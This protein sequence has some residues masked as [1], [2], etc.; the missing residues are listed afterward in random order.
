MFVRLIVLTILFTGYAVAQEAATKP[1]ETSSLKVSKVKSVVNPCDLNRQR[2]K[3][4]GGTIA[5]GVLAF[6]AC[7]LG[8]DLADK[9]DKKKVSDKN[10]KAAVC[11]VAGGIVG[12]NLAADSARRQCELYEIAQKNQLQATFEE[13]VVGQETAA[14]VE[15]PPVEEKPK[16]E[17]KKKK[18]DKDD[19]DEDKDAPVVAIATF[20]GLEHFA[21][22]SANL[23]PQAKEYF[24]AIA[25]QYSAEGQLAS[26][27][28]ELKTEKKEDKLTPESEAEL[29]K[30]W[31][32]IKVVLVGHTDDTGTD[33]LN[34]SLS[35]ARA[36][37]VAEVFRNAG[38]GADKLYFQGAGSSLPIG[39]NRTDDGRARNRRVEVVE[40]PPGADVAGYLALRKPNPALFRPRPQPAVTA[41]VASAPA[42]KPT[43]APQPKPAKP[44][45]ADD[46]TEPAAPAP[47]PTVK[48][49][50]AP[51][52]VT[53]LPPL[54]IDFGGSL[55]PAGN[56]QVVAAMGPL[57]QSTGWGFVNA[58]S[59]P[60]DE[61]IYNV[62]CTRDDPQANV[63]LPAKQLAT[64][65]A[66]AIKTQEYLPGFN[67]SA[68]MGSVNGHRIGLN[69]V[70]ILREGNTA[71]R[72]PDVLVYKDFDRTGDQKVDLTAT[73]QVKLYEGEQGLLYRVFVQ[74]SRLRCI[75][76]VVPPKGSLAATAGNLYY[77]D[78]KKML[79]AP[80]LPS[81]VR[82]Q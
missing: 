57:K 79:A 10:K 51:V 47:K 80:Y 26:L 52:K 8:Q 75:D 82:A 44:A 40:L 63:G 61:T 72:N 55:A 81:R 23:T 6:A 28:A 66:Q 37:S 1:A 73:S 27:R 42:P 74:K 12:Y 41:I 60:G 43:P 67:D 5:A 17:K 13:V 32:E 62:P 59:A 15:A 76:V 68:W 16:K 20:G 22:G 14:A 4:V 11:A 46:W 45:A 34:A 7:R 35:E 49:A 33:A 29:R 19:K 78:G 71:V 53:G 70:A 2:M 54:N 50:P 39:D 48:S 36:R 77:D 38:I 31:A 58:A 30:Q 56:D 9:D 65:A 21:S 25:G 18:G 3:K 64:G 24:T 69:H